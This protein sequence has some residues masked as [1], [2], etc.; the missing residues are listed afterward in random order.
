MLLHKLC[1]LGSASCSKTTCF[2]FSL[3]SLEAGTFNR[4]HQ[5]QQF[6]PLA[7]LACQTPK[8]AEFVALWRLLV[9]LHHQPGPSSGS[10]KDLKDC[11][12]RMRRKLMAFAFLINDSKIVVLMKRGL[13]QR[14][15]SKTLVKQSCHR[16]SVWVRSFSHGQ[17]QARCSIRPSYLYSELLTSPGRCQRRRTLY[18][19]AKQSICEFKTCR[20]ILQMLY[21]PSLPLATTRLT[22]CG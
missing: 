7:A 18:L 19:K 22:T 20:W 16:Q 17:R 10:R 3:S 4:R 6:Y 14:R 8:A 15:A 13:W 1:S 5:R 9:G 12:E 2:S 11:D 21:S